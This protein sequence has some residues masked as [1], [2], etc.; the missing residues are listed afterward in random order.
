[1]IVDALE[2]RPPADSIDRGQSLCTHRGPP[3]V[4]TSVELRTVG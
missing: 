1:L 4:Q 2:V 3:L